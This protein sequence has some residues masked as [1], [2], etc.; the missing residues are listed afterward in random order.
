V[1]LG[2]LALGLLC[3]LLGLFVGSDGWSWP[4]GDPAGIGSSIVWDLRWPRSGGAWLAGALLGLAGALGQSLFRNPLADPY[5]LGSASGA[6]LGVAL[7]LVAVH[8]SWAG[9]RALAPWS[10][11][12]LAFLGAWLAVSLALWWSR[13]LTHTPRL[14]LAG[15]VVGVVLSAIT[16]ALMLSVPQAWVSF[17]AFMLGTTQALDAPALLVLGAGLGVSA[18]MAWRA[19]PALDVLSLGEATA[20]SLGLNLSRNRTWLLL[21]MTLATSLAVAH[22]GLIAFV[23]L[24]APHMVRSLV[25]IRPSYLWPLSALAGGLLLA[26]ADGVSRWW[27]APLEW[28]V[29]VL[30]ALIGGLYLLRRLDRVNREAL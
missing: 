30:T 25:Q 12:L 29:G 3:V 21:S 23:G 27:W 22:T 19:A 18:A 17:Q 20:R 1:A 9:L 8:S 14:L 4:G 13:G 10:G 15:V 11:E 5:L 28:P 2:L 26:L 16:S 7:G 6:G 24:A